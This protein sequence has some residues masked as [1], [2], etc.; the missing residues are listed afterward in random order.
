ML[1]QRRRQTG[2]QTFATT[3]KRWA[4]RLRSGIA[5]LG[6]TVQGM[7]RLSRH[8]GSQGHKADLRQVFVS[9]RQC[10]SSDCGSAA[11][12]HYQGE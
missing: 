2:N 8:R 11:T 7:Y 4:N 3:I 12:Q 5:A 6:S 9:V 10:A 1:D